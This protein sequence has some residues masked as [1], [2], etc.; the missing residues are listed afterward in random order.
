MW[1]EILNDESDPVECPMY[2][3]DS[4]LGVFPNERSFAKLPLIHHP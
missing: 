1:D 2:G 4:G 3:S